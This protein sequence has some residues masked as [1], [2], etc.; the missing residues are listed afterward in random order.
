MQRSPSKG[1]HIVL[2]F[3]GLMKLGIVAAC[4]GFCKPL[5][6]RNLTIYSTQCALLPHFTGI[7]NAAS[8]RSTSLLGFCALLAACGALDLYIAAVY[9]QVDMSV[10]PPGKLMTVKCSA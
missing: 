2:H 8:L 10:Q 9:V 6:F 1:P 5:L 3:A 7:S 4:V